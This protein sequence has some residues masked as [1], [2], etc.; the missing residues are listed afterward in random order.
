M[1]STNGGET[2]FP[3]TTG[4]NINQEFYEC[5]VDPINP[6]TLYVAT[7]YEGVFISRDGGAL[8]L[9]YNEGLYNP[10]AA[11]NSNHVSSPMTLSADHRYLYFGSAGSG[12]FRR[13]VGDG[14]PLFL[15]VVAK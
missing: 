15:P 5:F 1:K 11:T 10:Y 13:L 3:I 6:D 14:R 4:L 8:W 2:W 12:A 7:Q 9:P